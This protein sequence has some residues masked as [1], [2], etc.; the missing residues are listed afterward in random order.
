MSKLTPLAA[1]IDD[2][3]SYGSSNVEIIIETRC[4]QQHYQSKSK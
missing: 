3:A 1:M 4:R 2:G